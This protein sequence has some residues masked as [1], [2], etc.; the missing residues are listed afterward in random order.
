MSESS[1]TE[2]PESISELGELETETESEESRASSVRE[3]W[4]AVAGLLRHARGMSKLVALDSV[5]PHL[6]RG[7]Q[8]SAIEHALLNT[9]SLPTTLQASEKVAIAM[10]RAEELLELV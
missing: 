3:H 6:P 2:F 4:E 1:D 8:A 10:V 9:N 5:L 7:P